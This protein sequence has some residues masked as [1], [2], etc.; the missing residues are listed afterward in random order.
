MHLTKHD[1][2]VKVEKDDGPEFFVSA[3]QGNFMINP[4]HQQ[5][6]VRQL[7]Q[8]IIKSQF[9][10]LFFISLLVADI[11]KNS[12]VM[13]GLARFVFYRRYTLPTGKNG[14]VFAPIPDLALEAAFGQ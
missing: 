11:G 7:G 1:D 8:G 9:G 6:P 4:V 14:S 12:D 2:P 5:K 13:G 10:D 3:G